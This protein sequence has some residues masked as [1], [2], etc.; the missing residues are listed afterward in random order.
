MCNL[1]C[2]PQLLEN[3]NSNINP[4]YNTQKYECSQCPKKKTS[5]LQFLLGLRKFTKSGTVSTVER[6]VWR[7]TYMA[8][9]R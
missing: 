7:A 4:V 2:T 6:R 3:D 5:S 9:G 1:S 8:W